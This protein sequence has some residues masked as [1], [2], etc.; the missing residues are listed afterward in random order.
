MKFLVEVT[1]PADKGHEI[2]A[3]GGPGPVVAELMKRFTPEVMYGA[4]D[5]R[6]LTFVADLAS[7]HEIAVLM[8]ICSARL[9]AYPRL[10]PVI[11]ASQMP[12]LVRAVHAEAGIH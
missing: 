5:S 3:A 11:S 10:R 6:T 7:D 8:E 1:A 9:Y 2:D 4:T 12:E